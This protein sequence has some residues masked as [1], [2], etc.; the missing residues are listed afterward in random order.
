M[1]HRFHQKMSKNNF[2]KNMEELFPTNAMIY[3]LWKKFVDTNDLNRK[4][5]NSTRSVEK[6]LTIQTKFRI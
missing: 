3:Y 6:V 4:K 2:S 1:D 5:K